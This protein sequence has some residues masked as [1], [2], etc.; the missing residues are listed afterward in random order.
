MLSP[1]LEQVEISLS[2]DYALIRG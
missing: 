1:L 2:K